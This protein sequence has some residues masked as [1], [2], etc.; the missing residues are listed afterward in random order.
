MADPESVAVLNGA[1]LEHGWLNLDRWLGKPIPVDADVNGGLGS[2][3]DLDDVVA[4]F[5]I[6]HRAWIAGAK[7]ARKSSNQHPA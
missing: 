7:A 2:P 4:A 5:S 1:K 3:L 6:F